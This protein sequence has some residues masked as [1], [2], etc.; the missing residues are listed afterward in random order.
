[1]TDPSWQLVQADKVI[2]V[3]TQ[4]AVDMYWTDCV[5]EPEPGWVDLQPLFTASRDAWQRGDSKAAVEADEAIQAR[6]LVLV[7][8]G[9]GPPRREFLIRINGDKARFRY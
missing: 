2:G 1:M 5:F 7:P 9:G 4:D 6:G 3:L 8:I